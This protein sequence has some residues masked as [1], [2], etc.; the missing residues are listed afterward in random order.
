MRK[1]I[2]TSGPLFGIY[3]N[4]SGEFNADDKQIQIGDQI[5]K[6]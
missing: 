3:L 1:E 5:L 4:L 6:I 2:D